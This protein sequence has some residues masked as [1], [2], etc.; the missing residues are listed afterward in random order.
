MK[1]TLVLTALAMGF[2]FG[3]QNQSKPQAGEKMNR[4][5]LEKIIRQSATNFESRES[6]WEFEVSGV[7]MV[8]VM[9]P[10]HDRMRIVAPVAKLSTV[11]PEQKEKILEAN[12]HSALDARY[13][14]SGGIL[15]SAFIHP[16]SPLQESE[17]PS[18]LQQVA[19]LVHTFGTTYTS[20]DLVFG[21]ASQKP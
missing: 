9:D 4:S 1:S 7:R 3:L 15:W 19:Q 17:V 11:T 6:Y 2:F 8:C 16:L 21:G 12:F 14:A 5:R 10:S 20:S 13:A 18:A